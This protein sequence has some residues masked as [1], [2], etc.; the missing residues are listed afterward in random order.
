MSEFCFC[1]FPHHRDTSG[2]FD[3]YRLVSAAMSSIQ[4]KVGTKVLTSIE[5]T[6]ILAFGSAC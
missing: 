3:R 5:Y 2:L 6:E 4:W 1:R